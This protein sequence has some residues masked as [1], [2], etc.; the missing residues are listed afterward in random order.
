MTKKH[1]RR[2]TCRLCHSNKLKSVVKFCATPPANAFVS[3]RDLNIEQETYPL[4]VF[5]CC[6]CKHVQLLDVVNPSILFKNYV[7]VSGTSPVFIKHFELGPYFM[8]K[9]EFPNY[10]ATCPQ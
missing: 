6:N 5:F 2:K 7:Y 9:F 4:E 8:K 3:N 1:F 10:S